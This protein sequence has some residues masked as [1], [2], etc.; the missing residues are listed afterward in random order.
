[1]PLPIPTK[2]WEDLSMDLVFELPRTQRGFDSIFVVVDI[3]SKRAPFLS[4]EK[5][6]DA[7]YVD[8][9][10]FKEV[11][12]LHGLPESIVSD[13]DVK[14]MSYFCKTLWAKLGT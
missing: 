11:V 13:H 3:F 14:F 8:A 9:L 7:F 6:L 5:A 4:S 2:P 12:C 1:M 10:F